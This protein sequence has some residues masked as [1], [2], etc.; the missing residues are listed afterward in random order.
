MSINVGKITKALD[1]VAAYKRGEAA[2][3]VT[4]VNPPRVD[5]KSLRQSLG[6]SQ[7]E[8]ARRYGLPVGTVRN[9]EQGL[10]EP[11]GPA[12]NYLVLIEDNP[13]Q[14]AAKIAKLG[15]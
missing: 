8:F 14:I 11:D 5:V 15:G 10:R 6:V 3:K 12:R 2:L 4:H 7:R 1:E 13:R 9:W